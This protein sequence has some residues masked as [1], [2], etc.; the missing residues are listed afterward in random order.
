MH[1]YK[2]LINDI[3]VYGSASDDRTGTGTRRLF[4]EGLRFRN[5]AEN[6]PL[7]TL[8]YTHYPAVFHELMWFLTG[9]TNIKY[10]QDNNVHIWD[11]WADE[12]GEVGPMYGSQWRNCGGTHRSLV[13]NEWTGNGVDQ[14]QN[15]I[16][17]IKN[18]PTSRRIVV[19]SWNPLKLPQDDLGMLENSQYGFMNLAPCHMFFQFF[20]STDGELSMYVYQRSVDSFLGLPFNIAS[21]AALLML[22]AQVTNTKAADLVW[23]GGDVHLY[24][25]HIDLAKKM[26]RR[27]CK[28]LPVLEINPEITDIDEFQIEDMILHSYDPHPAIKGEISV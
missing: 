3:L 9:S 23:Q 25:N 28:D 16:D 10:L 26:I 2:D 11:E 21:Y 27:T 13:G 12:N 7:V 20:V 5:V 14:L 15:A 24:N 22:V 6:F 8:K 1:E 17:L 19:D 18:N 4:C